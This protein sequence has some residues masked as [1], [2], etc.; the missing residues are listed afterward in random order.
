LGAKTI[1]SIGEATK[2]AEHC[3]EF[4]TYVLDEVSGDHQWNFLIKVVAL[5]YTAGFAVYSEDDI[6][7]INDITAANPA[8][9]TTT[10]AH[11]FVTGNTVYVCDVSGTT[12]VNGR[13]YPVE[14]VDSTSFKLL[15]FDSSSWTAY[16][17]DGK[18][19]RKESNTKYSHGYTYDLPADCLKTLKL[20]DEHQAFEVI[21]D[22]V[23]R[24]LL[25]TAK[26][27][28]LTYNA[29]EETTTKMLT[30]F[31]NCMA[32]RLAAELAI[33]LTK[34]TAKYDWAMGMY[35]TTLSKMAIIDARSDKPELDKSD[36]WLS[37]GNFT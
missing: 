17:A 25:T 36:T 23:N 27:A 16:T 1:S 33:P 3:L 18:C 13:V 8:V 24:R 6:K 11:G 21:G 19:Y 30:R 31:V 26:D 7:V 9:V 4:W 20:A 10:A 2:M 22:D 14:Y 35:Y 12:E 15:G 32:W 34:K 28:V 5:D 37:A 29:L